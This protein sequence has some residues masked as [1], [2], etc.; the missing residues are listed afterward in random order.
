M[1]LVC[2]TLDHLSPTMFLSVEQPRFIS[3]N[4]HNIKMVFL[5]QKH[6]NFLDFSK[7]TFFLTLTSLD[8]ESVAN[9]V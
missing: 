9:Q 6:V 3:E 1:D 7:I 5:L 2:H 8:F 4:K